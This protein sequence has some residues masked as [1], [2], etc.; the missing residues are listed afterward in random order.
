MS[1]VKPGL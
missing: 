1:K